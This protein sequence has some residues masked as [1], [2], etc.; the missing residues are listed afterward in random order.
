M[1][2]QELARK[3][4]NLAVCFRVNDPNLGHVSTLETMTEAGLAY[5]YGVFR[6]TPARFKRELRLQR[7]AIA[8][9][10]DRKAGELQ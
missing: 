7:E 6:G 1:S 4:R 10:L 5:T 9:A 8:K 2:N 3:F